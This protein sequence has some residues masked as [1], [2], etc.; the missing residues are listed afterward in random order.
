[1]IGHSALLH[2]ARQRGNGFLDAIIDG[3]LPVMGG[4]RIEQE[5]L[6]GILA[7]WPAQKLFRG[8]R[9]KADEAGNPA[10]C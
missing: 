3:S 4:V 1:M 6:D 9:P 8:A 5:V 10:C 2:H 7:Q